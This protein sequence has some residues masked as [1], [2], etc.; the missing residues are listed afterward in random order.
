LR[1]RRSYGARISALRPAGYVAGEARDDA[2][3][4]TGR[5]HRARALVAAAGRLRALR[6][7]RSAS[8]VHRK[9][10]ACRRYARERLPLRAERAGGRHGHLSF[11]RLAYVSSIAEL[12]EMPAA[13]VTAFHS[14][15]NISLT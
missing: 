2:G 5:G 8:V 1:A 3:P 11:R 12:T 4:G 15:G 14:A 7:A 10:R 13:E 9:Y 6:R